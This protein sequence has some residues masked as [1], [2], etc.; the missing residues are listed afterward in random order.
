MKDEIEYS[1]L[2]LYRLSSSFSSS[3]ISHPSSF[4]L[5]STAALC[6]LSAAA[7]FGPM[8][9]DFALMFL[10]VGTQNVSFINSG[11]WGRA[12]QFEYSNWLFQRSRDGSL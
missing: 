5:T 2:T 12:C 10:F 6:F 9:L 8:C 11:K 1:K 4:N 7:F 3:F